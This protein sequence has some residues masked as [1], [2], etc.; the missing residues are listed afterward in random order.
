[1]N[2]K[3]VSKVTHCKLFL[4]LCFIHLFIYLFLHSVMFWSKLG[5]SS[6]RSLSR[7]HWNVTTVTSYGT[8]PATKAAAKFVICNHVI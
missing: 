6:M 3:E 1:M 8:L 2:S 7:R 4:F 5:T